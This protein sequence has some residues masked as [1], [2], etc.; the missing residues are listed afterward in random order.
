MK[1][2]RLEELRRTGAKLEPE[3]MKA[4]W[5]YCNDFDMDLIRGD[6]TGK[7]TKCCWCDF[8]GSKLQPK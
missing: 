4:G 6:D 7:G 8:D 3:E 1:R 5:H 2:E